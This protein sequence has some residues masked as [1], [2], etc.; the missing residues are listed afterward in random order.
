MWVGLLSYNMS[1]RKLVE[2]FKTFFEKSV[3]P[4]VSGNDEVMR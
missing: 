4:Y 3:A 1:E 2:A